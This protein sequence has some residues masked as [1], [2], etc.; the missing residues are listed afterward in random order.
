MS[1]AERKSD[2][3]KTGVDRTGRSREERCSREW[4]IA[5]NAAKKG[6]QMRREN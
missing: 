4:S 1:G 2:R 5:L 6:C 3:R